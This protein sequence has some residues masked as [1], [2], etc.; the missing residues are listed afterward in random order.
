MVKVSIHG[1][2]HISHQ[3]YV[4]Q[5]ITKDIHWTPMVNDDGS[6]SYLTKNGVAETF[7]KQYHGVSLAQAKQL[8]ARKT[9]KDGMIVISGQEVF[10]MFGN[11][12]LIL[13]I[14]KPEQVFFD[15]YLYA[16]DHSKSKGAWS[17][18][19]SEYFSKRVR[20]P[21]HESRANMAID[22]ETILVQYK[23]PM[24]R[25][26]TLDRSDTSTRLGNIPKTSKQTTGIE[27]KGNQENIQIPL[28]HPNG[29]EVGF[30]EISLHTKNSNKVSNRMGKKFPEYT[31]ISVKKT[32]N[33]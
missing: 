2:P 18:L 5:K 25:P 11:E 30:Y 32:F 15:H 29:N 13:D 28:Y 20:K 17:F 23:I 14:G 16:R 7:A 3:G 27:F 1:K 9:Y 4:L 21:N 31:Y 19:A 10:N 6:T 12:A 22:G 8:F 24:Y 26:S 33:D